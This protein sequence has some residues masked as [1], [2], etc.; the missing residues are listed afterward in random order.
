MSRRSLLP[1]LVLGLGGAVAFA[2]TQRKTI[3]LYGSKAVDAAYDAIW[4]ALLPSYAQPYAPII[5]RVSREEGVDPNLIFGLG[6]R[7]TLWGTSRYLDQPGPAGRGDGGHGHGLMQIDDRSWAPWLAS[8][9]WTDPY[10]NVKKGVRILKGKKA[11]FEGRSS[12]ANLTD[13][14]TV[15]IGSASAS[16]LKVAPGT[17]KD[18]R[19]LM[20]SALWSAAIAAYNTGEGN[21]LRA[22][23]VGKSPEYTTAGGDY[24]TDVS[25]RAAGVATQFDRATV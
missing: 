15:V 22:L 11:F 1:Y 5:L 20:N 2:F 14:S 21:V 3:M 12:V 25:A 8:N 24:L 6:D 19:P 18:P 13:G 4:T 9:D 7:E 10:T 23:A 16:R 17:Y